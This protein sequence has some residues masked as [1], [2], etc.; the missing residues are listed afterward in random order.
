MFVNNYIVY[1]YLF[2]QREMAAFFA[3]SFRRSG[4]SFAA[5]AFPPF[6]PP[7]LPRATAAGFFSLIFV[8]VACSTIDAASM[9]GLPLS[10]LCA[11]AYL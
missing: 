3:I 2:D 9:F 11:L 6:N 10:C 7:S 1:I 5:L 8:P 4:L